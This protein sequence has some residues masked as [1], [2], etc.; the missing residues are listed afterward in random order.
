MYAELKGNIEEGQKFYTDLVDKLLRQQ[1]KLSDFKMARDTEAEDLSRH[2]TAHA[3]SAAQN[4]QAQGN[5]QPYTGETVYSTPAPATAP[6][7][8]VTRQSSYTMYTRYGGG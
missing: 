4:A 5:A 6:R 8:Q 7:P 3:S 1:T 2:I